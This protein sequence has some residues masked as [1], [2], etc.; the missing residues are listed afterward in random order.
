MT[1]S[2]AIRAIMKKNKDCA[3][4]ITDAQ[5]NIIYWSNTAVELFGYISGEVSGK[6]IAMLY[7]PGIEVNKPGSDLEN[8]KVK[9]SCTTSGW[10]QTK[11]GGT[12]Y[13][14]DIVTILYSGSSEPSGYSVVS[15]IVVDNEL[16]ETEELRLLADYL[17][18]IREEEKAVMAREIHDELG[19]Q[20]TGLKMDVSWLGK[21]ISQEDEVI[22]D[23]VKVVIG[24]LDDTVKM[25]RK[26][27]S[28]LRPGILDDFGL[29]DAL[30]WYSRE[31]EKKTGIPVIFNSSGAEIA[32]N[33][34]M[35]TGLFR[36]Y[37]ES[38]N[39]MAERSKQGS[40]VAD[41]GIRNG[42][43]EW[44]ITNGNAGAGEYTEA[45]NDKLRLIDIKER[46]RVMSGTYEVITNPQEGTTVYISV[47]LQKA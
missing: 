14:E 24:L 17:T 42:I 1:R 41:I 29:I 7:A 2:K 20:I 12:I 21:K 8:A 3:V 37:Q 5:G 43:I 47:P 15:K 40:I 28:D 19:Q 44:K 38:L 6:N 22:R 9:G 35:V 25:V 46:M 30:E 39:S 31:F 34:Q 33:K 23:K 36:I 26:M 45:R 16:T 32:V 4:Y 11:Q 27:A 18:T 10:K 13:T